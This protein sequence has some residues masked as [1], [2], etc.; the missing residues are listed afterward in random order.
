VS[1]LAKELLFIMLLREFAALSPHDSKKII[2]KNKKQK[3]NYQKTSPSSE[4]MT[5]PRA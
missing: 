2:I 1:A 5:A 3:N 4:R